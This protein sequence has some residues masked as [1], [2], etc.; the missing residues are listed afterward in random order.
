[1]NRSDLVV[2]TRTKIISSILTDG[3]S[4]GVA[5]ETNVDRHLHAMLRESDA[6]EHKTRDD[7]MKKIGPR[8]VGRKR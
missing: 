6:I 2:L 5:L 3:A 1:M 4:D 8:M 7:L